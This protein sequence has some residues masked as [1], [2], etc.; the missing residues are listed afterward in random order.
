MI[1]SAVAADECLACRAR[2]AFADS[3]GKCISVVDIGATPS[4]AVADE[5]DFRLSLVGPVLTAPQSF[6]I[7]AN[8]GAAAPHLVLVGL[9]GITIGGVG[10]EQDRP[11]ETYEA[12]IEFGRD[13]G[14]A[15]KGNNKQPK[16]QPFRERQ[17]ALSHRNA[18]VCRRPFST[19]P[20]VRGDNRHCAS[21][22]VLAR[23]A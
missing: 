12:K 1:G 21:G 5:E 4:H 2:K 9:H 16:N 23:T 11:A 3:L 10:V 7:D 22:S 6:G 18:V 20:N 15:D 19:P 8:G 13:Y 17:G 14:R